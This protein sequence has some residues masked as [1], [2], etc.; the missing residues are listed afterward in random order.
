MVFYLSYTVTGHSIHHL[1]DIHV[2]TIYSDVETGDRGHSRSSKI[3]PFD[4]LAMVS[5]RSPFPRNSDLWPKIVLFPYP[6]HTLMLKLEIGVTQG[7]RKFLC[8]IA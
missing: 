8:L 4:S 6:I 1:Q 2:Q 3:S 7:H 5:M